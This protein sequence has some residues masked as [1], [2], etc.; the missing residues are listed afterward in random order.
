MRSII[1]TDT[2]KCFLCR[3]AFGTDWHHIF[4]GPNRKL[5]E[6]DGLK[7]RVC[8][9]CHEEIHEGRSSKRL[10][11]SLHELGQVQYEAHGHTREEF[12]AR[13]GRNYL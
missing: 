3:N 10:M 8:R 11:D 7:I 13:Y 2:D 4:G 6:K 1:Q 12:M 9:A 5:S